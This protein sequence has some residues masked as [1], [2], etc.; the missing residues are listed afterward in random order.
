MKS[1]GRKIRTIITTV[2]ILTLIIIGYKYTSTYIEK[3]MY[4]IEHIEHIKKYS[5]EY[6]L[7]P[8]LVLSVIKVESKFDSQAVSNKDARGLMQITPQTGQWAAEKI[9]IE[10]YNDQLLYEPQV[11]IR[12]GTWYLDNL[13]TQFDGRMP[14]VI[15]AYNGGSGNVSKWLS[16][17][18]YSEDGKTL[19]E[20]PF[21]E[22]KN[23]VEKV[24]NAYDKYKEIYEDEDL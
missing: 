12:I 7:D 13:R 11:N 10:N 15:A 8:F 2:I 9:N 16:D 4:P 21:N 6:N 19:K 18:R 1:L 14:L 23:Y 17:Q 24:F 20:I 5:Q 3:T 22:T